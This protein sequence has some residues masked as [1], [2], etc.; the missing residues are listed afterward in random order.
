[1][2]KLIK[3]GDREVGFKATASTIR[4]YR[5][6]FNRDLFA[7]FTSI[8]PNFEKGEVSANDLECFENIAYIMAKQ[9]DSSIPDDPDEWLD[10]F[11]MMSI[12]FVLPQIVE[13]WGMNNQALETSK[14]KAEQQ[15]GK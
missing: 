5:E 14:K 15:S 10:Q 6:R 13:L 2:E 7:D 3:I 4:R 8:A 1:M 11:E 9:Y 12:Y